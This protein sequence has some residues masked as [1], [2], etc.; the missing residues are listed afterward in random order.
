[1]THHDVIIK[2]WSRKIF[3]LRGYPYWKTWLRP[4]PRSKMSDLDFA[5]GKKHYAYRYTASYASPHGL[6]WPC[7]QRSDSAKPVGTLDLRVIQHYYFELCEALSSDP[8]QMALE[9]YSRELISRDEK[10][11]VIEGRGAGLERAEI[12]V[13]AI[14]RRLV[15]DNNRTALTTF[16][17]LLEKRPTLG[18]ITARMKARLS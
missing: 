11:K 15:T 6:L 12:L 4:C 10:R 8:H 2:A 13:Q 7:I 17:Q 1:M 16:C 5:P 3:A 18:N 9:M 14:E